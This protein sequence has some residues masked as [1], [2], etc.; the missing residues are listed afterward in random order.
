M[1]S[2]KIFIDT[3]SEIT[4]VLERI[5][6][7]RNERVVLVVPDRAALLSSIT[8]L[9]LIKRVI[10][11]SNKLVV[12]V[13]LDEV[14]ASLAK[15]AGLLVVSRVGEIS[16]DVWERAQKLKF[17]FIKKSKR[18]Y[19]IPDNLD[20]EIQQQ[21]DDVSHHTSIKSTNDVVD[22]S[23]I[24]AQEDVE[25]EELKDEALDANEMTEKEEC[26]TEIPQ[27]RINVDMDD[28]ASTERDDDINELPN[29]TEI[30]ITAVE[31]SPKF[32]SSESEKLE[33][34][35]NFQELELDNGLDEGTSIESEDKP[36][37]ELPQQRSRRVASK[38]S[39]ISNLSFSL[40]KDISN[41]KKN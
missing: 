33:S 8:G 12:L 7:T 40:G 17:E 27:I 4:F 20:K 21:P 13:T 38:A 39:G 36:T 32:L 25:L 19:Y 22:I 5:L 14:G 24:I 3:D 9:K 2:N 31:E 11:K 37:I 41:E 29:L 28:L 1:D 34:D 10:D 16:E 35:N 30:D 18:S 6:S 15:D 23:S 26:I